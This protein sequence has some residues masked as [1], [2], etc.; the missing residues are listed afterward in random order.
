MQPVLTFISAEMRQEKDLLDLLQISLCCG[1]QMHVGLTHGMIGKT[2]A[3]GPA[4]GAPMPW[5]TDAHGTD[6]QHGF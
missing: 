6:M 5:I 3:A 4:P 2:Q 1:L